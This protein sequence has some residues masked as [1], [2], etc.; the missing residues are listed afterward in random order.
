MKLHISLYDEPKS[1]LC[2]PKLFVQDLGGFSMYTSWDYIYIYTH[3]HE[4]Q[5]EGKCY[6]FEFLLN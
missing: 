3:T 2:L 6:E 4:H 1:L 5:L